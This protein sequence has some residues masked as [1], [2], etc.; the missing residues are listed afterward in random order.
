MTEAMQLTIAQTF[1]ESV[2]RLPNNIAAK[3]WDFLRDFPRNPRS[4]GYHLEKLKAKGMHSAKLSD[5]HRVILSLH[6]NMAVV[7]WADN[8]DPAYRWAERHRLQVS[9]RT[10]LQLVRVDLQE[11]QR[12]LEQRRKERKDEPGRLFMRFTDQELEQDGVT[13]HQLPLIRALDT[14]EEFEDLVPHLPEALAE[15]LLELLYPTAAPEELPAPVL[16]VVQELE[17]TKP[18]PQEVLDHP[19]TRR[20]F[21]VAESEEDLE[22]VLR[23]PLS[24]WRVFLHP[25]QE[26]VVKANLRGPGRVTGGAGTGKTVVALHRARYLAR[27]V[28]TG[29]DDR[30]LVTTFSRTLADNLQHLMD[31]LCDKEAERIEVTNLHRWCMQELSQIGQRPDLITGST[32]R[33]MVEAA[34]AEFSL[35]VPAGFIEDEVRDVIETQGLETFADY[36]Q[37]QRKG[38][39]KRLGRKDRR[40]VWE[41]AVDYRR[42]LAASGKTDFLGM[43][44]RTLTL[45]ESGRIS[46]RYA[47]VLV[48][49]AQDLHANELRLLKA[50]TAGPDNSLL[51][52][53][54][55]RQRIYPGGYSLSKMGIEVRGRSFVLKRNYRNTAE[56]LKAAAAVMEGSDSDDLDGGQDHS[57]SIA[58]YH[59]PS[60]SLYIEPNAADSIARVCDLVTDLCEGKTGPKDLKVHEVA[61]F[62][63]ANN[64]LENKLRPAL[65]ARGYDVQLLKDDEDGPGSGVC[66]GTMHRAKGMEFKVCIVLGVGKDEYPPSYVLKNRDGDQRQEVIERHRRLLHVAMSRAR[67][68]LY[69][70]GSGQ[71]TTGFLGGAEDFMDRGVEARIP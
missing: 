70:V 54:D 16:T 49:E 50:M 60:P 24:V 18:I 46:R 43:V 3:A 61:I 45:V 65:E 31:S 59:G 67:D 35:E 8:H 27:E 66:L 7:L 5:G 12:K 13:E 36:A 26:R 6:G 41:V 39:G 68:A 63:Y 2:A 4:P 33:S 51:I 30:I 19:E 69:L 22:R 28:F 44:R 17:E 58:L 40:L 71:E 10:G 37:A 38:R 64:T 23:E 14:D 29:K 42:Q 55:G 15:T 52:V 48:D 21:Y 32:K 47:A 34:L 20:A 1:T 62:A 53:G 9:P 57:R 56:I 25:A 11:Q